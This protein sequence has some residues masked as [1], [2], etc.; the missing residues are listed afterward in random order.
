MIPLVLVRRTPLHRVAAGWKLAALV[1][2]SVAGTIAAH[3]PVGALLVL[4]ATFAIYLVGG[5]GTREWAHQ[6]WRVKWLVVLLAV[7]QGIFLGAEAALTGTV[8]IVGVILLA[9]AVTLTT[10]MGEMLASIERILTPLR[11]IRVDPARAAFTIALAIAVIPVIGSLAS[12]IREAQRARGV[13]LGVR[14]IVTLLVNALRHA[15]DVGD[16][17]TARGIA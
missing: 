9:A 6:L 12:Q 16:A 13:R 17:L 10:P 2:F 15:D 8:R 7:M 14:W 1:V 11:W 3:R 4:A 5:I